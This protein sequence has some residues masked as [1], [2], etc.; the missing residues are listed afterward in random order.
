MVTP[1]TPAVELLAPQTPPFPSPPAPPATLP[2]F[3]SPLVTL[4]SNRS[5][6]PSPSE[7]L[8]ARGKTPTSPPPPD[9]L[10]PAHPL[11]RSRAGSGRRL[12]IPAPFCSPAPPPGTPP[13]LVSVDRCT[14]CS[15]QATSPPRTTRSSR[16][17]YAPLPS[18]ARR[19][20]SQRL[21]F[22]LLLPSLAS[23]IAPPL[24]PTTPP[25]T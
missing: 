20:A 24:P 18:S 4:P 19:A 22:L 11:V 25:S 1:P 8:F 9:P 10:Q 6:H 13:S 21:L 17:R 23:S 2:L 15:S 3:S 12:P 16:A 14:S 5:T 7:G